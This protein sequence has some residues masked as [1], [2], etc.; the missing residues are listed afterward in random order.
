MKIFD[1]SRTDTSWLLLLTLLR[2]RSPLSICTTRTNNRN[3]IVYTSIYSSH[4]AV[5]VRSLRRC[6]RSIRVVLRPFHV[7]IPGS[8]RFQP[9]ADIAGQTPVK[10]SIQ[11]SIRA[12]VLSQWKI[13]PETL[14]VIWPKKEGLIHVK[15]SGRH[16]TLQAHS[17][18]W[19][20]LAEN[21]SQS[22]PFT[23]SL[24]SFSTSMAHFIQH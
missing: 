4:K 2:Y 17:D 15:W 6:S 9:S 22:I 24:S 10:S 1:S 13:E 7:L 19:L 18:N 5:T 14:E 21:T 12:S 3:D 11:R 8:T 20:R 16:F 23:G